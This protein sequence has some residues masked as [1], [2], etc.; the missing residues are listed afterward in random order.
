MPFGRLGRLQCSRRF[1][2]GQ[3]RGMV[4]F[5]VVL[6]AAIGAG[7]VVQASIN[8]ELRSLIGDPYRTALVSTTVSS[9]TLLV[10]SVIL[11]RRP[12]PA[13]NVF[14]DAPWWMW[15]GGVLG[16][17][18]VAAAAILVTR[19]G[20]AVMFTLIILGQLITAVIMDHY[21][22]IGLNKHPIS[23]P[24]VVGITMVLLGVV[25]VRRS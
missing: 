20:S 19:L 3:V 5:Y 18:Y 8:G 21:G 25:I 24:R 22:M 16:A 23:L 2:G 10:L 11:Y 1:E 15:V 17:I 7:V 14:T 12:L 13:T 4:V 6:A 9:I